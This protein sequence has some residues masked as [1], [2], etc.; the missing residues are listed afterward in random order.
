MFI[1]F[2]FIG[3]AGSI[4]IQ[5]WTNAINTILE[6][7][8]LAVPTTTAGAITV[9]ASDYT[10]FQQSGQTLVPSDT[11]YYEV[12]FRTVNP[13][14]QGGTVKVTL[15]MT[16]TSC[17]AYSGFNDVSEAAPATCTVSAGVATIT[18]FSALSANQL[19]TVALLATNPSGSNK[20][21]ETFS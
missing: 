12:F 10:N 9:S 19:L 16:P 11:L 15:P 1:Y 6:Q 13:V 14:P 8:T 3:S 21:I 20:E 4:K 2:Q 18:S 5:T 7:V 17:I